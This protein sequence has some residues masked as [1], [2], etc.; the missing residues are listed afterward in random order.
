MAEKKTAKKTPTLHSPGWMLGRVFRGQVI[1]SDFFARHWLSTLI[2]I[3]VIM[4][5]ITT[6]YICQTNMER[7][8]QLT[9]QLEIVENEKSHERSTY[10]GRTRETAMQHMADSLGLGLR[11]QPQPPYK[12]KLNP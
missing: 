3:T 12:I 5:Y 4:I 11:V 8:A 10:M 9:H 2:I 7:I 6:K 1:S